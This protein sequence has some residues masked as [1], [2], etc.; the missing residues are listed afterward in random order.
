VREIDRALGELRS[1]Y[2]VRRG[3]EVAECID[4]LRAILE[5]R[6]TEQILGSG[7]HD[8]IDFLQGAFVELTNH[9]SAA[10]FGTAAAP[11][12]VPDGSGATPATSAPISC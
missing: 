1:Q 9:L 11:D 8:F 4:A 12:T 10:F 6:S 5:S 3:G 2:G 7:L